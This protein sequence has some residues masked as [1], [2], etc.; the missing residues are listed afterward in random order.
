[1]T[2]MHVVPVSRVAF[3]AILLSGGLSEAKADDCAT[4][5]NAAVAQAKVPH[6]VTH[7]TTPSG[8]PAVRA[9]MI[10]TADKA[11]VQLDG[12]WRSI[13]YS[14]Q[15]QIDA[16][17]AAA[18]RAEQAKETC[19]KLASDPVN[20]EPASLITTHSIT[21]GKPLDARMWISSSSG[22]PLKSEVHLSDGTV[23][24]DEFRY[25]NVAPPPGV[26]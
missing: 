22:L 6:A 15:Q 7:V 13:P 26:K 2:L 10:F 18:K 11:Y 21:N 3:L 12:T 14:A 25:T 19:Q 16:V 1:M 9:E 23:V 4:A 5:L 20:G 24:A 17:N 8:K